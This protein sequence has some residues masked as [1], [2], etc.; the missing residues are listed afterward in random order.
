MLLAVGARALAGEG[1]A[2]E[3]QATPASG[4]ATSAP[5]PPVNLFVAGPAALDALLKALEHPDFV[6]LNGDEYRKLLEH[7]RAAT[8]PKELAAVVDTVAVAGTVRAE[9]A[10]FVVEYG[11]TLRSPAPAWVSLRLDEP[12]VTGA[13]EAEQPVPLRVRDGSWEVELKGV[14]AHRVRVGLK[15]VPRATVDG[16]RIDFAIPE[17]AATRF[18]W[19]VLDRVTEATTGSGELVELEAIGGDGPGPRSRLTANLTPRANR[20]ELAC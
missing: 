12:T 17:A 20:R 6:L 3:A 19:E 14:G 16:H 4:S 13:S 2:P 1:P 11:I 5:P 18:S 8:G 15:L 10:D 9:R 7:V